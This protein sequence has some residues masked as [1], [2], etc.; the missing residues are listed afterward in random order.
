MTMDEYIQT[1]GRSH[2]IVYAAFILGIDTKQLKITSVKEGSVII[3]FVIGS[4]DSGSYEDQQNK[5]K[6]IK[7]ALDKAVKAGDM[8]AYP[9]AVI[10]NY[11]SGVVA[12]SIFVA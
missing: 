5:L 9:G 12:A 7:A 1:G 3:D 11:E 10:L 2:W 4:P 6:E 8:N